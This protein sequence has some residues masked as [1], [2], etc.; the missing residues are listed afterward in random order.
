MNT[1]INSH[2]ERTMARGAS[3]VAI[4]EGVDVVVGSLSVEEDGPDP[5][6]AAADVVDVVDAVRLASIVGKV[7]ASPPSVRVWPS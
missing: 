7:A 5:E 2:A 3:A 4:A 6:V 1:L